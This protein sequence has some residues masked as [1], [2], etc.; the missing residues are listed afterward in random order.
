MRK[1]SELIWQDTQHQVL[2]QIL[3]DIAEP[4]SGAEVLERLRMYTETHFS[5]EE[6]YMEQLDYPAKDAHRRA[7]DRFREEIYQ[8][9]ALGQT[10][11]QAYMDLVSVFLSEWLTRHVFGTDKELEAFILK[12]DAR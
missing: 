9:L 6:Q 12:A 5:L 10:H 2:F 11:D 8:L 7:H 1:T 4:G 3:D